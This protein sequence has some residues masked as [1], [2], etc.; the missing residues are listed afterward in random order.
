LDLEEQVLAVAVP[1]TAANHRADVAV[2]GFDFPEQ[3]LDVAVGQD[4]IEVATEELGDL[5]KGREPLPAQAP[6][7]RRSR[8]T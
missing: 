3:G 5:V 1:T 4:A 6:A 8:S 2:D 7:P